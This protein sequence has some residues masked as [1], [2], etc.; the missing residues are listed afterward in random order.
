MVPA[1]A[2]GAAIAAADIVLVEADAV[3]SQ[4]A[5][6]P[7][8]S[9]VAAAV[10]YT[11]GVPVWLVAGRGRRLPDPMVAA[12]VERLPGVAWELDHEPLALGLVE[13]RRRSWRGRSDVAGRRRAGVRDGGRAAAHER[14]VIGGAA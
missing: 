14:D 8:G 5:L 12:M 3:G 6:A 7:I 2:A 13:P 4:Q 1:E 11:A 10:A 9:T